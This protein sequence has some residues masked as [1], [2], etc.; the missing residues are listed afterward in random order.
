M[1]RDWQDLFITCNGAAPAAAAG[2]EEPEQRRGFFRRLRENMRKTREALGA[3]IQATLF[4][5]DVD[6]ETWERLE[7]ALIMADVG[8]TTPPK[9]VAQ[10]EQEATAG[11]VEGG[12]ALTL[13][14]QE[15]LAD[16]A[17][18]K[19]PGEDRIDVRK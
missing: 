8:A 15:L 1:A 14:L 17:R 5:G 9:V 6:E 3:E 2:G 13:R 16:I 18:P 11:E 7:E 12:E 4:E 19:E 10:L